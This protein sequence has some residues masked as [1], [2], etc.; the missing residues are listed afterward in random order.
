MDIIFFEAKHASPNVS[1]WDV[2]SLESAR[3]MF[4]FSGV[5]KLDLSKWRLNPTF[6]SSSG[7][8]NDMFVNCSQLE[9][10]KKIGRA[11]V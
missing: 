3:W 6:L 2:S 8:T 7:Y 4:D 11:H 1:N 9:Y 5:V 10:L